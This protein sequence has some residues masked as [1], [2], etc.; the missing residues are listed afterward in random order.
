[1]HVGMVHSDKLQVS[2]WGND[3]GSA[4]CS[5]T[6]NPGPGTCNIPLEYGIQGVPQVAGNGGLPLITIGSRLRALGVGNYSPTLQYVWSLEGV[7][8]VTKV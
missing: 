3:Y 7:D 8:A 2:V 5:G 1:M 4:A 6:V